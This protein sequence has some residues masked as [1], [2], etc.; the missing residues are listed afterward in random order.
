V[1]YTEVGIWSEAKLEIVHKYAGAYST[2]LASKG[3]FEHVYIDAFSGGGTHKA[4]NS[5]E[6]IPGSPLNALDITPPF[7]EHHFI[8]LDEQRVQT[9][10]ETVGNRE[11]VHIYHGDCNELLLQE[12]LPQV[13]WEQYRRAL[14]LLD[15]YG[16][17]LR[18]EVIQEAARMKTVEIFLNFPVHD[19]N[20]N[21]LVR[22]PSKMDNKQIA[23]MDS[24]WG[25]NSWRKVAYAT[26]DNLF[27]YENKVCTND[28]LAEAFRER[29][30]SVAGFKH[31]PEPVYMRNSNKAGLYYLFFAAHKPTA[32]NIVGDIFDRYRLQAEGRLF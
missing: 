29:L 9:L 18:W 14:C 24:F 27:G 4:K 13:K 26:D 2:I 30:K 5:G 25:D 21:V 17:D 11:D 15:P 3:T 22:D 7:T 32:A 20:R 19:M 12:I 31:V 23:R 10:E 1:D 16:L 6:I 28:T 8:D